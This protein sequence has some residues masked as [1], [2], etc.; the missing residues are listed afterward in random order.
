LASEADQAVVLGDLERAETLLSRASEVNRASADLAYRHGRVLQDLGLI[1]RALAAFCA[2]LHLDAETSDIDDARARMDAL[3]EQI[4]ARLAPEARE[5]FISGLVQADSAFYRGAVAAFTVAIE[6]APNWGA[7]VYNRALMHEQL[8][9]IGESLRDYRHY[10]DVAPTA[11]DPVVVMVSERIGLLEA[12][13]AATTPS[14]AGAFAL[15]IMPGMGHY[16]TS[17]PI[18]GTVVLA[19]TGAAVATGFLV[20]DV[21]VECL[22][23]VPAGGSCP[24]NEIV[25]ETKDR[26]LLLP[27]LGV[28]AAVTVIGAVEA[29]IK[30]RRVRA[31]QQ[32]RGAEPAPEGLTFLAPSVKSRGARVDLNLVRVR[33]R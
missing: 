19:L 4:R 1:D 14:P 5:A 28:A 12:A 8:G 3:Y 11:V 10:L 30:A 16:Y 32:G 21:T 17:R 29:L 6:A 26:P 15:G 24:P 18:G 27:G 23:D 2:S 25:A 33:F 13:A 20:A 22:N 9:M 7:P 31:N